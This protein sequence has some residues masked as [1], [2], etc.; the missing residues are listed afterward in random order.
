M[1]ASS[2][3][4]AGTDALVWHMAR[5]AGS[6]TLDHSYAGSALKPR[7]RY[8]WTLQAWD[9]AGRPSGFA[10]PAWFETGLMGGDWAAAWIAGPPPPRRLFG[11]AP[12]KPYRN[13]YRA[14]PVSLL[15]LGF[16]IDRPVTRAR[17]YATALGVYQARINGQ[18]VDDGLLGPGWTDY[19]KRLDYQT[20]DVDSSVTLG[21]NVLGML[22][23]EGWYSG[24]LGF[25]P[26][27]P[28]RIYGR[29]PQIRALLVLGFED[30]TEALLAT[31]H[32]WR[33]GRGSRL[34]SDLLKGEWRDARLA[35]TGWD[36][37]GFDDSG[38]SAAPV[39]A[40]T[41][42]IL[43]AQRAPPV[44]V[45]RELAPIAVTRAPDG[46][47]IFDMGQ[48]MAG[49]VRLDVSGLKAGQHL[50]LRHAEMLTPEGGL[51]TANLRTAKAEDIYVA[52]TAAAPAWEPLFTVHGFR[53]VGVSGLVCEPSLSLVRGRVVNSDLPET[54][55]FE[56][57]S[58]L[59]N[60]LWSNILWSQRGNLLSIPTDCPQRDERLGWMADVQVFLPTAAINMD[61]RAFM[62]K[63]IDDV[64]DAQSKNGAFSDVSPRGPHGFDGAPAWGDAGVIVPVTLYR[65][66]GDRR[67][68]ERCYPAMSRWTALIARRNPHGLRVRGCGWNFGD[69][70]SA[71]ETTSKP[72][73]ATAYWAL[74][75]RMMAEAAGV[76]GQEADRA[77]HLEA[78]DRVA[79]AFRARFLADD[80]MLEGDTQTAYLL[81]LSVGLLPSEGV[82]AAVG[83]LVAN[84]ERH[85]TRIA[86][87]FL[88]VR[89]ILPI[90]T[91]HGHADLA[92]KLALDTR[93]P[94]WLYGVEQGATTIWSAGM[95]GGQRRGSKAPA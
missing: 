37:P 89:L 29:Q 10:P 73:V 70:L 43:K 72:L 28:R 31:G 62:A 54:A 4:L 2:E 16:R 75:L 1:A 22:L 71:G 52:G 6:E 14:L 7:T 53:Y 65:L 48:N 11:R 81:A 90:L 23:G 79:R 47:W 84:V 40:G 55:T 51:Y 3:D 61:M 34:Y 35:A 32:G 82:A 18:P 20:Y 83:R 46:G 8:W 60:A 63:W 15:R 45:T 44:R 42:A 57:S 76:L 80:G 56:T 19:A 12:D 77:A 17:L 58:P 94:S 68:L 85:G 87:G 21:D 78:F 49:R 64:L 88:G 38:W 5:R 24:Y 67:L 93:Y 33:V 95:A 92:Y 39:G 27:R 66:Y 69:W 13:K 30:G 36:R 91:Q 25:Y 59:L 41:R 86:T 50:R 26:H 9:E 74:V